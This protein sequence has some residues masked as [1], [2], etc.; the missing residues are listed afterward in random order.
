MGLVSGLGV[1]VG[2][3]GGALPVIVLMWA[4]QCCGE[5][6]ERRVHNHW[7]SFGKLVMGPTMFQ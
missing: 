1:V 2:G 5:G 4:G 3:D 7:R 6:P